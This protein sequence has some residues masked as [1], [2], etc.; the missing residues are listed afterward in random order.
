MKDEVVHVDD[1]LLL[2]RWQVALEQQDQDVQGRGDV[3]DGSVR[4]L[5]SGHCGVAV[6]TV[7]F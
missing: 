7:T 2:W 3:G 1:A 6:Q 5:E 4:G